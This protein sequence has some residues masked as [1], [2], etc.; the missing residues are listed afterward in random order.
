MSER[1]AGFPPTVSGDAGYRTAVVDLLGVMAHGEL[2][3]FSRLAADADLAPTLTA[4][5][6]CLLY[7][8]PSPRD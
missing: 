4:K 5:A 8:S 1:P 2:T 3:G 7:T 6:A